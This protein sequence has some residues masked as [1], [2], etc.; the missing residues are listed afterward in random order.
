MQFACGNGHVVM[1]FDANGQS[2]DLEGFCPVCL[3]ERYSG[4]MNSLSLAYWRRG[5]RRARRRSFQTRD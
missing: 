3:G 4:P 2:V 1:A 5:K